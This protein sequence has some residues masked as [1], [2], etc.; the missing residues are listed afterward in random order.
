MIVA[1]EQEDLI[2]W[3]V[4]GRGDLVAA[5]LV[6]EEILATGAVP[7]RPYRYASATGIAPADEEPFSDSEKVEESVSYCWAT[8]AADGELRQAIDEFIRRE[9]RGTV[10]NILRRRYLGP[11][12]WRGSEPPS[13]REGSALSPYDDL[14]KRYAERYGFDWR[15][16]VALMYQESR[17]DPQALS[18]AGAV[19]LLQVLP[20]TAR[21][22]GVSDPSD[23]EQGFQAGVR[24]LDWLRGRFSLDMGL[25]DRVAFTIAAY[26]AGYGHVA[27][28]R[29]VAARNGWDTERWFDNVERAMLLLA[30]PEVARTV[31]NGY[32]RGSEPVNHVRE[33][34]ERFR[35]Y[36]RLTEG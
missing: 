31:P 12:R 22:L 3:L 8:R 9:Y 19:G 29:R 25:P 27:D 7:S 36:I 11:R 5:P 13:L 35:A 21:E 14:A 32:C 20:S 23:P 4:A 34:L 18:A 26:N 16:L 1:P 10:Y 30:R 17:F 24:Y 33:I 2:P 28:A 6:P 15:L